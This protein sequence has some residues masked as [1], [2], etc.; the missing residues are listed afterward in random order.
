MA[1]GRQRRAGLVACLAAGALVLS[2]SAREAPAARPPDEGR[3]TL[4]TYNVHGLPAFITG[5]ET[6]ARQAAIAPLLAPFDVIG[7]QEDFMDEGHALL[8]GAAPHR[9]RL[10]FA[11]LVA[12]DRVYGSGLTSLARLP[13][14]FHTSA[15]FR[16]FH[17]LLASGSDG[18]ASK[19]F[20]LLRVELAPGVE[21]DVYNSHLDAGGAEGDQ[22]A[23]AAQVAQLTAAMQ[24]VSGDRAV[25]FLGD[26]N[27]GASH[28]RDP[29]TLTRWLEATRLTCACAA[30]RQTCCGRI[31]RVLVRGGAGVELTVTRWGVAPGFTDAQ[32]R[33]LS[34]HEPLLAELCWR[35]APL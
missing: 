3:L 29:E 5:D 18:L 7:L 27:L 11:A 12:D 33:P 17:G 30:A 15:H 34:D 26:T 22:E 16:T 13:V 25:V 9:S 6:L 1:V 14:V 23:R 20:Q 19:G 21:L 35:R 32:G 31:D 8:L 10:R 2:A 24:D 28:G 4:L